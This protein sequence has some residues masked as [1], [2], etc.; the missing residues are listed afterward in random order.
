MKVQDQAMHY[1]PPTNAED[2]VSYL[3]NL[4]L[5]K[6]E[7][8]KQKPRVDVLKSLMKRT[9]PNRFNELTNNS[10]T[11][12]TEY[13]LK[14]PL[15]KKAAYVSFIIITCTYTFIQKRRKVNCCHNL[16]ARLHKPWN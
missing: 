1:Y 16:A 11:T 15:L 6:T 5:L 10:E 2:D 7:Q 9:F 13:I 12:T 8:S 14:F 3:R 4:E